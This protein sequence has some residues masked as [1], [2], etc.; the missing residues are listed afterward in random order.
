MKTKTIFL[1]VLALMI[2]SFAL[3]A[4]F[5]KD[6]EDSLLN[7]LAEKN[8]AM[9][10]I[11]VSENG[12]IIYAKAVGYRDFTPSQMP[13]DVNTRYRI[14]SISK[15]FTA[16]L[17]FQLIEQGRLD[18]ETTLDKFYPS[19]PNAAKITIGN[20]L[21]H[22]SG[23]HSFTND[24]L[25][26]TYMTQNKS[27]NDMV[28]IIAE[29]KPDFEP[30]EKTDYSNSNFYLLGLIV[31][32]L[33]K[34]P[35]NEVLQNNICSKAGLANTYYGDKT[36][37]NKN[38]SFSFRF[39]NE[40][41]KLPETDMSIPHGAGAI[42]STPSDLVKF[43]N[44]IFAGQLISEASLE[45]MKTIS[46]KG[47][48][49]GMMEFPYENKKLYGHGGSI[50]GFSSM[51]CYYPEDKVAFSYISNG[52]VFST[53]DIL[54]RTINNYYGKN[55]KLPEF[56]TYAVKPEELEQYT[57]NYSSQQIPVKVAISTRDGKLF[58]QG[59]GQ[60]EIQLDPIDKDTFQ[61]EPA[62]IV[63]IFHPAQNEFILEQSGGKFTFTRE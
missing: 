15:M 51:V 58:G 48:G 19:I 40:W 52:S 7:Y 37:L 57:G 43:I 55:E 24:S 59:S 6:R 50:D 39:V 56:K 49:M 36:D 1:S 35:Y 60:S 21:G 47:L 54:L 23:I 29:T 63:M 2:S 46:D 12:K 4:Q 34:K 42:V 5:N 9:G 11:A 30:G 31:E 41:E 18:L 16:T 33:Y 45:K 26:M 20:M 61:F 8:K 14:G 25:Y 28:K 22:R 13:S 17:I 32:D 3:N 62:G 10:S 27:K 44:S 53:N 38:E